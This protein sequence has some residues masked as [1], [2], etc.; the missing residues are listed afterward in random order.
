MTSQELVETH[1]V[2]VLRLGQDGPALNDGSSALDLIGEAMGCQAEVVALPVERLAGEFFSLRSGVAGE[3]VQKF[4]SY[5]LRLVVIGDISAHVARSDALRDF[6]RE[7]NR[8]TQVWFV[9][10]QAELDEKLAPSRRR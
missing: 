4:V 3:V 2:S 7:A 6:V 10:D 1:G 9:A 8:G 5:R